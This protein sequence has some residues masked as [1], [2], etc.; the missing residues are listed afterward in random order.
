MAALQRTHADGVR[1]RTTRRAAP[2]GSASDGG[3]GLSL[4][5]G[6]LPNCELLLSILAGSL[7]SAAVCA[8]SPAIAATELTVKAESVPDA[9]IETEAA[10]GAC[11]LSEATEPG[12][13]AVKEEDDVGAVGTAGIIVG[14]EG[15]T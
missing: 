14:Q 4:P 2:P 10:Q 1:E 13:E 3:G 12:R 11:L 7:L 6:R 9:A 5:A 8:A 15:W